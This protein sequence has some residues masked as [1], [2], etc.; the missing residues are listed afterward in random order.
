MVVVYP[1]LVQYRLSIPAPVDRTSASAWLYK[2]PWMACQKY[3]PR[4]SMTHVTCKP[5][6]R[7]VLRK[8]MHQCPENWAAIGH[9][10]VDYARA[11]HALSA[12]IKC[13]Y[14]SIH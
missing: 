7:S 1:L 4:T 8:S 2:R 13:P 12:G 3:Q 6:L 9:A 11:A 10:V 5:K 14:C